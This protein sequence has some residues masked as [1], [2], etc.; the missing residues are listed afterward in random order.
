[1]TRPAIVLGVVLASCLLSSADEPKDK[2]I[3]A[4][5]LRSAGLAQA[6]KEDKQLFLIFGSPSCGWCRVFEKYHADD[7][8]TKVISKHLVLVKVDVE[9]N[10]GGQEM[11]DEYGKARGVPAFVILNAAGKVLADSG[12]GDKNIG[13]PF[14][15]EEVESYFVAMKSACPKLTYAEVQV[16][17]DKLKE[18]RPKE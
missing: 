10:P 3:A 15:P 6:K 5:Q 9:E 14:K 12:D 7:A 18:V 17:R 8:V 16:L 11:Y 13:F 4:A 1:M 2:G